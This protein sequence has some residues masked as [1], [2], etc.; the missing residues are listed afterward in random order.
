MD[1]DGDGHLDIISGSYMPGDL[2]IFRGRE[3]GTFAK[4]VEITD[5]KGDKLN[6]AAAESLNGRNYDTQ[7]LAA[8]PFASDWENDGDL[9]LLVG[10]IVGNVVLIRNDAAAPGDPPRFSTERVLLEAGG[11]TIAVGGGDSGPVVADWNG[12]D[13]P[14]L[15]VGCGDG[16]V[17]FYRNEGSREAP[18]Y[19]KGKALI[20]AQPHS[21]NGTEIK[22][23][24]RSKI[25]VV[26]Y[27]HDGALDLL[28][29]DFASVN[30]PPPDLDEAA[31]RK[32]DALRARS[33]ILSSEFSRIYQELAEQS[34]GNI[35][36]SALQ[37]NEA[38][39]KVM[40]EYS[41]VASELQKLEG[42]YSSHGWV[43]LYLQKTANPE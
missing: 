32:R 30:T 40:E 21:R 18:A 4:G 39:S 19:A 6:A 26:D 10:N 11:N 38:Y 12:D 29:G 17:M 24:T 34:D 31:I 9:D 37:E 33:Q 7:G 3:D 13:L 14:D 28:V 1:F 2:F 20:P 42:G 23:G 35:D 43:W 5:A 27:N 16:S 15:V 22:P 8:V 36:P 25:C 41:A